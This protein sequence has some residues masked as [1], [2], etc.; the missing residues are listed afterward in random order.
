MKEIDHLITKL[1]DLKE[2]NAEDT[3]LYSHLQTSSAID[4][5]LYYDSQIRTAQSLEHNQTI[6]N[7]VKD[8]SPKMDSFLATVIN[9][10]GG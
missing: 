1:K 7:Q 2:I 9:P 6:N 4:S 10:Y 3:T 5:I 8:D